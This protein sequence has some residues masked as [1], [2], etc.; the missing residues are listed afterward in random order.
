MV[1]ISHRW[2]WPKV[3]IGLM[4]LELLDTVA[5]LVLFGIAD[6]DTYRTT[7]WQVGSDNGFNSSPNQILYAY[8]NYRPI[9]KTPFV[10]SSVITALNV[11]VSVFSMFMLLV[12]L[13]M[14]VLHI[15]VPLLSVIANVILV[16]L[17]TVSV[18][19]QAGPDY[20]DPEHPSPSAWYVTKS[21]SYASASGNYG[22]CMQAK[23]SFAVTVLMLSFL[24]INLVL[25]IWSMFPS[26]EQREKRR[27][28]REEMSRLEGSPIS[29]GPGEKAWEM[30][31]VPPRTP[32]ALRQPFTPRTLAF[33]TLDRKLPLR[34]G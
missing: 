15:W 7:M 28:A 11:I 18:Y 3:I 32:T 29:D 16:A 10:W 31:N 34:S 8:A 25:G 30:R 4:V 5:C 1:Y 23:G 19:G 27:A 13:I 26:K 12:K 33:N 2:K 21:C 20:S 9:P 24:F 14:F 17:W 22:Y 6:P